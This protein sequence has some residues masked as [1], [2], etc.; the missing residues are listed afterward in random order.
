MA[1]QTQV[2]KVATDPK[3]VKS[4]FSMQ[5]KL[6]GMGVPGFLFHA[7][8]HGKILSELDTNTSNFKLVYDND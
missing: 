5:E 2:I 7:K 3:E 6:Q 8:H 4:L 1:N